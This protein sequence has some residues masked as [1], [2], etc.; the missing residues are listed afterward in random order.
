M[1][2]RYTCEGENI[3]PPLEWADAPAETRSFALFME[4]MDAPKGV[5]RHCV[6]AETGGVTGFIESWQRSRRW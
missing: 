4:D 6:D 2:S 5:F 1:P 3:A